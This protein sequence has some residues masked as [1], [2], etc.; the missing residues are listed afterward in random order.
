M[1]MLV[2]Y[3]N[4]ET[5]EVIFGLN[6][7]NIGSTKPQ[8]APLQVWADLPKSSLHSSVSKVQSYSQNMGWRRYYTAAKL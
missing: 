3:D 8:G 6:T 4:A 2:I 5:N 7:R 1:V